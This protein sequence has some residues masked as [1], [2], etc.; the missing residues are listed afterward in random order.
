MEELFLYL[1]SKGLK[2]WRY[3]YRFEGKRQT[4]TFG[5]YPMVSLREAREKLL[6][7][8]KTIN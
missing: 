5:S 1:S 8:K 7:A 6:E 4:L 3:D 2:S